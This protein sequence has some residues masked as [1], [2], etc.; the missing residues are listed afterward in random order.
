MESTAEQTFHDQI[1]GAANDWMH[2][3]RGMGEAR[4]LAYA[5]LSEKRDQETLEYMA[6]RWLNTFGRNALVEAKREKTAA[7]LYHQPRG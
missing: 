3:E 7:S 4:D 5:I 2:I 6:N 1:W